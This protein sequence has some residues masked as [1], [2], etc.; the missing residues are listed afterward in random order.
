MSSYIVSPRADEDIFEVW[1]Y[2]YERAGVEIANRVES[3]LYNAFELLSQNPRIGHQR[4]DLTSHSVLFLTVYS[5]MI[6]Y[7]PN[8]PLEIAR[9][10]EPTYAGRGTIRAVEERRIVLRARFRVLGEVAGRDEKASRQLDTTV[11]RG[12]PPTYRA[13]S[14]SRWSMNSTKSLNYLL[15]PRL[16]T[17]LCFVY[18][19][20]KRRK[21]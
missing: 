6:V 15:T 19:R 8:T 2:L 21:L 7:R 16:K 20:T 5:Y 13:A 18:L 3:E 9:F 11:G 4:S 17:L 10:S 12:S 1:R 14:S